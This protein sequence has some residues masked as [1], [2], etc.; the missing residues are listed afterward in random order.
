MQLHA[1]VKLGLS[2]RL[3]ARLGGRGRSLAEGG[4]SRL[5]RLA[6]DVV[7][8]GI[9]SR[10]FRAYSSRLTAAASGRAQER[11]CSSTSSGSPASASRANA[12]LATGA[13]C[14]GNR[15]VGYEYLH[16]VVDDHS[17]YAYVELHPRED[18]LSAA[19]VLPELASLGLPPP[20]GGD[21]R[22][23]LRLHALPSLP[24]DLQED[25]SD[26]PATIRARMRSALILVENDSVPADTR[27]W[28]ECT[29][30]R[31]A[32]W[33]VTVICPK[34]HAATLRNSAIW[35]GFRFIASTSARVPV[36]SATYGSTASLFYE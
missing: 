21:D 33:D 28:A 25:N 4:R 27:V 31:R 19:R 23:R 29:S 2:G 6:G 36:A 26:V 14:P 24:R 17:R 16:C 13:S 35:M 15:G 3:R 9:G 20:G 32:G 11:C 22:Q 8:P 7:Y 34:G 10:G 1:N 30:L 5:Q 12:P 18:G